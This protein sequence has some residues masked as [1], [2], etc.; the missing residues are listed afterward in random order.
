[1]FPASEV[2]PVCV[3]FSLLALLL[4]SSVTDL[5]WHRIPNLLLLS[6][7]LVALMLRISDEGF[8]GI[9]SAVSGL[10]VGLLFLLPL[11][12]MGSMG[13]GDVKL[14]GVVGV[15]LGPWGAFVAGVATLIAGALL[16]LAYIAW[17]SIEPFLAHQSWRLMQFLYAENQ[18]NPA[19]SYVVTPIRGSKFAYAPAIA[20]GAIF[21]MWQ[22]GLLTQLALVT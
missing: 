17:R 7:L 19:P 11:Y 1:M 21:S 5:A 14:L 2:I 16:G 18:L 6:A 9:L 3:G 4:I 10:V 22:Q 13:A 8:I 20:G 12:A 15:F